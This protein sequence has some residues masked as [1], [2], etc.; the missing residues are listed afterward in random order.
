MYCRL[1]VDGVLVVVYENDLEE[2][3]VKTWYDKQISYRAEEWDV[4]VESDT[5]KTERVK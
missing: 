5:T 4:K 3:A 2:Y 1:T